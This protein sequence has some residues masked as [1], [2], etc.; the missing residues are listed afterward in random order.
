MPL[1]HTCASCGHDLT[2]TSAP[3]DPIYHWPVVVCPSCTAAAVRRSDGHRTLSRQ[4][5]RVVRSIRNLVVG[6]LVTTIMSMVLLGASSM[7]HD[8]LQ[9]HGLTLPR[10]VIALTRVSDVDDLSPWEGQ[11]GPL[12]L[13]FWALVAI[14]GGAFV[15]AAFP[16][17]A[18]WRVVA[19]L[20][21][22][23]ALVLSLIAAAEIT[24][25]IISQSAFGSTFTFKGL[26][27]RAVPQSA[28][29]LLIVLLGAFILMPA[30]FPLA[31]LVRSARRAGQARRF[32][33]IRRRLSLR[34][35][36]S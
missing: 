22:P 5:Q 18:R 8:N 19:L 21:A 23:I 15:A 13:A 34:R 28:Q 2:R 12:A 7:L 4:T 24:D 35:N 27:R 17:T 16:H 30:G 14:G 3:L 31:R 36:H 26:I 20:V 29:D 10:A 6:A 9:N 25:A 32:R 1:A 11:L 33:R